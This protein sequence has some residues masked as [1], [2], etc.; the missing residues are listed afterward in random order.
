MTEEQKIL[1]RTEAIL[2]NVFSEY[3]A[4]MYTKQTTKYEFYDINREKATQLATLEIQEESRKQDALLVR[5]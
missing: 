2:K 1:F 4:R 5:V 3:D